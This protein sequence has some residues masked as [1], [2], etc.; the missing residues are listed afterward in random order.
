MVLLLEGVLQCVHALQG[1]TEPR[2]N[3]LAQCM[4]SKVASKAPR[5]QRGTKK[6][7]FLRTGVW[8]DNRFSRRRVHTSAEG[9]QGR[10]AFAS[11]RVLEMWE[12]GANRGGA[13]RL[14]AAA[15][16][17]L[18]LSK[19]PS[20]RGC[21][22]AEGRKNER[23]APVWVSRASC[24]DRANE[25]APRGMGA[26]S[27]AQGMGASARRP[28]ATR[29]TLTQEASLTLNVVHGFSY[30]DATDPAI[31]TALAHDVWLS[32]GYG[33]WTCWG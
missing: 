10:A 28:V 24:N 18:A 8:A 30:E 19:L 22:G 27:T 25:G 21:G 11:R 31:S 4:P 13:S 20:P 29:H 14:P 15:S 5:L 12:A 17:A 2:R 32:Q 9:R 26:R 16:G 33:A 6:A 23:A 3:R 7:S 1:Q